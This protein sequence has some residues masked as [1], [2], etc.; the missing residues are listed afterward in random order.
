MISKHRNNK[1]HK[2]LVVL[3]S[4][5]V[6]VVWGSTISRGADKPGDQKISG[7]QEDAI[8][9]VED[10]SLEEMLSVSIEI[11]STR[12]QDIFNTQS[13]VSVIDREMIRKYNFL[14]VAEVLQVVAGFS[15]MR[16]YLKRNLPTSR[17]ILQDHYANKVLVMINGIPTWNS[18]TGEANIERIHIADVERL[19]VLKGPA[20][21]LYGTNAYSGAVNIVLKRGKSSEPEFH[22]T[23]GSERLYGGGANFTHHTG[24][25]GFYLS[26]G[27]SDEAGRDFVFTDEAGVSGHMRDYMKSAYFNA[28]AEINGHSI[29]FN[30][31]SAHESFMGGFPA[32]SFGAGH[33]QVVEGLLFNYTYSGK[34]AKNH[35]LKA[36]FT[37][38]RNERNFSSSPDNS[39]RAN[40]AGTRLHGFVTADITLSKTIGLTL[41]ADVDSRKSIEFKDYNVRND[42]VLVD[43]NLRGKTLQEYSVFSQLDYAGKKLSFL[44]GTRLTKNKLFGTNVSSRATMVWRLGKR[45]SVKLIWGQSYRAPSFFELYFQ[46]E[47]LT[48]FGDENLLPETSNSFELSYLT[49]FGKVFIQ[50]LGY[51]ATYD[52]KIFRIRTDVQRDGQIYQNVLIYTNG[53][54]FKAKGL[55]LEA[56]YVDPNGISGFLNY[57]FTDGD[58][59]DEVAGNGHYNFKYIPSHTAS[60]G[61]ATSLKKLRLSA[62]YMFQSKTQGP[63]SPIPAYH[64][65]D[66]SVGFVHKWSIF[67]GLRHSI[68]I[69]NIFDN[70]LLVPEYVRRR[71]INSIPFGF[72]RR[73]VYTLN[74][75]F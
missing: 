28:G 36:G 23:A 11:S 22:L 8:T 65:L 13:T 7:P 32:F 5:L 41:G 47:L 18:V 25:A 34:L 56:K 1:Y 19:E 66:I 3:V 48:V 39:I 42:E 33:D 14:S 21:V 73:I 49:S 61:L 24:K 70:D 50:A 26:A 9:D 20:S 31:F 51:Y 38:D 30:G 6:I 2:S 52:N 40:L 75:A 16:T 12:A 58:N 45:N 62:V 71:T 55:E 37:Y 64:S 59:G 35:M 53:S 54:R 68:S 72:G 27:A 60:A 17:G 29:F 43:N 4:V 44:V 15:V 67:P 74:A 46:T 63:L 69:K 57:S 10:F